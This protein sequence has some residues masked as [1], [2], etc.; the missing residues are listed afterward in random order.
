[1]SIFLSEAERTAIINA[2]AQDKSNAGIF[3]RLY[4]RAKGIAESPGIVRAGH[5]AKWWYSCFDT[6]SLAAMFQALKPD[7]QLASFVRA[8][9]LELVRRPEGE[10]VGPWFRN[11]STPEP[12][13][14]LETAHLTW[15][16]ATAYDLAPGVFAATELTEIVDCLRTRAIPMC[17]RFIDSARGFHNWECVISGG[18]AVAAAVLDDK[19]QMDFAAQQYRDCC[20]LFEDDGSYGESLQY[21]NYAQIGLFLAYEALVRRDPDYAAT[22]NPLAYGR[23]VFWSAASILYHKP[24]EGWEYRP[25][26]RAA[27]FNDS[28]ALFQPTGDLLLHIASRCKEADAQAAGL[29][30]WLFKRGYGEEVCDG[31]LD[32]AS[33]GFNNVTG[34]LTLPL[35]TT[36]A[37]QMSPRAA[38]LGTLANFS[39][40]DTIV[41]DEW[42]GRTVLA[43]HGGAREKRVQAHAHA[44]L[45]SFILAHNK[46]RLL[47]DPGHS[48]YRGALHGLETQSRMHNTMTFMLS[49]PQGGERELQQ[50][51]SYEHRKRFNG[52]VPSQVIKGFSQ[53]LLAYE[54]GE[55]AVVGYDFAAAYGAPLQSVR[56]FWIYHRAGA[57]FVLDLISSAA[58]VRPVW[59]WVLNNHGDMLE[60][61]PLPPDRVVARRGD[62]GMKLF[63]LTGEAMRGPEYGF[64][65]DSYHPEPAQRGEGRQGSAYIIR[66]HAPQLAEQ[67][68]GLHA[69]ALDGYGAVAGWHLKDAD[70]KSATLESPE[71]IK[72]RVNA[73]T[74]DSI[75][76]EMAG[77]HYRL[78]CRE[79]NW[80]LSKS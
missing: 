69:I 28:A 68:V 14:N 37:P 21:A 44:D 10:W 64:V 5:T 48:C 41:R 22:F 42:E 46:E 56:R 32:L 60:F 70:S 54:I 58:P 66:W 77:A 19:E 2:Q 31:P 27:N 76:M 6:L 38:E 63:S 12:V 39:C 80:S 34:F 78:A 57:L 13:A 71:K 25:R 11:H 17:R 43:I 59:N 1:M 50:A 79:G 49:Q 40:G 36:A 9:T 73:E 29:A 4:N 65:H 53:C 26:A 18:L 30:H 51:I 24:Q 23:G 72:Y 67:H 8:A 47:V 33:F 61:K 75:V 52:G 7:A 74:P 15:A 3:W 16:V 35:L 20:G 62:A 55:L 45:G